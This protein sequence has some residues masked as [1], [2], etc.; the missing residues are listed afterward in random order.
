MPTW[1]SRNENGRG[2]VNRTPDLSC[3]RR[4]P[5]HSATRRLKRFGCQRTGATVETRTRT[6]PL[7]RRTRFPV[8]PR[9]RTGF[10]G[11]IRTVNL[12][13]RRRAPYPDWATPNSSRLPA[14]LRQII[15]SWFGLRLR[16][17]RFRL[18][19]AKRSFP[20]PLTADSRLLHRC[21]LRL[22]HNLGAIG[23]TRNRTMS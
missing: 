3:P 18:P 15:P 16:C 20:H 11:Q 9:P 13:L 8:A 1:P 6:L 22:L 23:D 14:T 17:D 21:S 12:S 10:G 7:R 4:A 2:A 5:F 19:A